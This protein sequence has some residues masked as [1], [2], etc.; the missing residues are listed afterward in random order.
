MYVDIIIVVSLWCHV[1]FISYGASNLVG[2]PVSSRGAQKQDKLRLN[3]STGLRGA[4][5]WLGASLIHLSLTKDFL[6]YEVKIS[7]IPHWERNREK[8]VQLIS[9]WLVVR[10]LPV[11][12]WAR[13]KR[14][15]F[16]KYL[17][18]QTKSLDSISSLTSGKLRQSRESIHKGM[19]ILVVLQENDERTSNYESFHA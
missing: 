13:I 2:F 6:R 4:S 15:V 10:N 18:K 16:K 7:H 17:S 5:R 8:W 3:H 1:H 12:Q 14:Y 11:K 19:W 9:T